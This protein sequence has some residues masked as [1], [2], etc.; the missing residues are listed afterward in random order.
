MTSLFET[1]KTR[2]KAK[3]KAKKT[4]SNPT[5][6]SITPPPPQTHT[7]LN[8]SLKEQTHS[9]PQPLPTP[10]SRFLLSFRKKILILLTIGILLTLIFNCDCTESVEAVPKSK[11][12]TNDVLLYSSDYFQTIGTNF[13]KYTTN[14]HYHLISVD[15]VEVASN[16][17]ISLASSNVNAITSFDLQ[18]AHA[19]PFGIT[20]YSDKFYIANDLDDKVY[21]YSSDGMYES[22]FALNGDHNRPYGITTYN[23]QFYITDYVDNKIYIYS[24]NGEY[25]NSSFDLNTIINA[26]GI[27]RYSDK[28]YI[29]DNDKVYIYSSSG[30][31]ESSFGLNIDNAKSRGITIYNDKFYV[32]DNDDGKVYI[33]SSSGEYESSFDLNSTRP[34][35]ITAYNN[36]LYIVDLNRKVYIYPFD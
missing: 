11:V 33:Y 15:T 7:E 35:G 22:S 12:V 16:Y 5:H 2:M 6:S 9:L 29:I 3:L 30:E 34:T 10:L 23:N 21:I 32:T 31:Y 25:E 1:T 26:F 14:F 24:N 36:K 19:N 4:L 18:N 8:P 27:T 20:R 13:Y 28:F 17:Y